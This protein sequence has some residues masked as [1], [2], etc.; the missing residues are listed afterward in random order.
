MSKFFTVFLFELKNYFKKKST[1]VVFLLFSLIVFG[2]TFIPSIMNGENFVSKFFSNEDNSSYAKSGYIIKDLQFDKSYLKDAKA[3]TD[4]AKLEE[5]IRN[6]VIEE[7]VVYTKD[8]YDYI[9]KTISIS[10]IDSQFKTTVDTLIKK[11]IYDKN[12]ID[13]IKINEVNSKIPQANMIALNN[14]SSVLVSY[15][16]LYVLSFV[17]YFMVITFGTVMANNVAREKTN[18]AMELLITIT[19]PSMLI[20]GKVFAFTFA[21]IVHIG[22]MLGALILGLKINVSHYTD[23]LKAI[24]ENLDYK[25][26]FIWGLFALTG[27]VMMLFMYSSFA[28]LVSRIEDVNTVITIPMLLF[29]GA[30]FANMASLSNPGAK[31]VEI[32]SYVPFTSYFMVGTRYKFVGMSDI[33]ILIS[34]AILLTTTVLIAFICIKVYRAATLRYGKKLSFFKILLRKE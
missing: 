11:D 32:L 21:A 4:Q 8:T 14:D 16:L 31:W 15:I 27:I 10:S 25:L 6:E 19:N 17:L 9:K 30:F 18:R 2:A 28:S 1:I 24:A 33:E 34:Y 13:L 23:T 12:S 7:A 26:L 20:L 3:Y 22:V 29:M 5:D